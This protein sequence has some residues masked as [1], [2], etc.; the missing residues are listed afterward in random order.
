[1]SD[2]KQ[3]DLS[4]GVVAEFH[5]RIS[6]L[7]ESNTALRDELAAMKSAGIAEPYPGF[8][9]HVVHVMGKHFHHD[10]PEEIFG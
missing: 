4:A 6:A 10:R 1:M 7:E 2:E 9:A 5:K 8:G 3:V